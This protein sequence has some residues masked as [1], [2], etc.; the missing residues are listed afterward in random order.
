MSFSVVAA[1]CVALSLALTAG[2]ATNEAVK[3]DEAIT[4]AVAAKP[5]EQPKAVA[6]PV[7]QE[8]KTVA[9]QPAPV[10]EA[11]KAASAPSLQSALDK[12]YFNFDSAT[13]SDA[14]RNTL[15]KNADLLAK[16]A[17]ATVRIEG[18]CDDRG[19]AEY[20]MALGERRAAA[21]K[22]YLVTLGVKA[23]LLSTVS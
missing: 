1:C 6:A 2:C 4:P 10:Q 20:N 14:A 18:N 9:A 23:D 15:A 22:Q 3:K 11:P 7:Q 21:A 8:P 16:N 5:V 19:S 17:A 13:L 12:I